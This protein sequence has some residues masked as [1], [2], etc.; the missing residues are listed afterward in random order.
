[1]PG[2]NSLRQQRLASNRAVRCLPVPANPC[3]TPGRPARLFPVLTLNDSSSSSSWCAILARPLSRNST[4][5]TFHC[6]SLPFPSF[7]LP[8]GPTSV[9]EFRAAVRSGT[10]LGLLSPP[11]LKSTLFLHSSGIST[12][13]L[14]T[15]RFPLI[16]VF[17]SICEVIAQAHYSNLLIMTNLSCSL[18]HGRWEDVAEA[19]KMLKCTGVKKEPGHSF[20][21][22]KGITEKFTGFGLRSQMHLCVIEGNWSNMS[23]DNMLWFWYFCASFSVLIS[24]DS[25]HSTK[26]SSLLFGLR[27]LGSGST[28]FWLYRRLNLTFLD[29]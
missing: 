7:L 27:V 1:M 17:V 29:S 18:A 3:S 12:F 4:S 22:V 5:A 20:I 16:P 13:H 9:A 24:L 23:V 14:H 19:R 26:K 15:R 28:G 25:P 21:E 6:P 8:C 2:S 10:H 11:T